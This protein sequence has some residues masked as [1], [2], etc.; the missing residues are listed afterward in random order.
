MYIARKGKE[1]F[2]VSGEQADVYREGGYEV[3]EAVE[4]GTA[5]ATEPP[6]AADPVAAAPAEAPEVTVESAAPAQ[7]AAE[8]G[9]K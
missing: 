7:E 6:A 9:K 4:N 2:H 8:A 3:T 5:E 1:S